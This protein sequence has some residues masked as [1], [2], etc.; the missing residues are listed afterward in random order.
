[1]PTMTMNLVTV[2][3]MVNPTMNLVQVMAVTANPTQEMAMNNKIL[4]TS[5]DDKY[6]GS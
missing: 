5:D 2:A 6:L 4:S 3:M 1:M